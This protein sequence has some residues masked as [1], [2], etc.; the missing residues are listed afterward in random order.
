[1]RRELQNQPDISDVLAYLLKHRSSQQ[2]VN[3]GDL[4]VLVCAIFLDPWRSLESFTRL[5]RSLPAVTLLYVVDQF[6]DRVCP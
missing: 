6:T 4:G 3:D 5:H 1:M 2:W